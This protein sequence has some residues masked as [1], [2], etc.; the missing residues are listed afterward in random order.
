V[1]NV[2]EQRDSLRSSSTII[3]IPILQRQDP[4]LV[5]QIRITY[6]LNRYVPN[7]TRTRLLTFLIPLRL[8]LLLALFRFLLIGHLLLEHYDLCLKSVAKG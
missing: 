6:S 2:K 8:L 5:L 1:L 4:Q 3:P 7:L